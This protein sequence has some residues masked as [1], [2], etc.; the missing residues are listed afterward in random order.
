MSDNFHSVLLSQAQGLDA[1]LCGE[2][3]AKRLGYPDPNSEFAEHIGPAKYLFRV[4]FIRGPLFEQAKKRYFF[5]KG[6][7]SVVLLNNQVLS[8][9]TFQIKAD[10]SL[11]IFSIHTPAALRGNGYTRRVQED[12]IAIAREKG[13]S[14]VRLGA[15]GHPVLDKLL[16]FLEQKQKDLDIR[17]EDNYWITLM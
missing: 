17:V 11:H 12:V 5:P 15:G 7:D 10:K 4:P 16:L 9:T 1:K 3:F 14:R 8:S 6:Y 13:C 2:Y